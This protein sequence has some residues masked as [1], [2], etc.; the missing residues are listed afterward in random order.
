[1]RRQINGGSGQAGALIGGVMLSSGG[2]D[3]AWVYHFVANVPPSLKSNILFYRLEAAIGI[4]EHIMYETGTGG[5]EMHAPVDGRSKYRVYVPHP[6]GDRG[7]SAR[8]LVLARDA[9]ILPHVCRNKLRKW[10]CKSR[11][12]SV[13]ILDDDMG[14]STYRNL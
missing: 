13:P 9:S 12:N 10:G 5:I 4:N 7:M 2:D 14:P 11:R 8:E 3:N 1:L 6:E